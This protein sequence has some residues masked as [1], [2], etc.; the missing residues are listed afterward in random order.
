MVRPERPQAVYKILKNFRG[1][2]PL[3]QLFWSEL[4]YERV[5]QTLSRRGWSDLA[6]KALADDPLLFAT[7]SKDNDF[8]IIYSRLVSDELL[9][10][11]ERPAVTHLLKDHPYALFIFSN[12]SQN[13]WHF[14]NVKY[15][16]EATKRRLFRRITIGPEER[17]R[18]ASE[19]LAL[20][21]L[22]SIN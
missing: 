14:L 17:I 1:I 12:K 7:G 18:T 11:H 22:A 13:R 20:L 10:G 5:N 4:S 8:Q 16:T 15:D 2:E 21:D 19:R 3:K 9:I 6:T